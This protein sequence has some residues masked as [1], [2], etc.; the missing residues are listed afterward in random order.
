M[1]TKK[2]LIL[3]SSKGIGKSI[4]LKFEENNIQCECPTSHELDTASLKK[5]DKF[6]SKKREYD[7]VILNTGGPPAKDFYEIKLNEWEK[8]HHQLFLGFVKIFQKLKVNRNGYI[9]LISSHTV[10]SPEKKL[11]LSNTYR[12]ALISLLKT[13][14]SYFSKKNISTLSFAL[15]PIKTQRLKKLVKNLRKFENKLP[16][17][18]AGEPEEIS[19]LI[20]SIV[21]K[22]IKYI[23]GTTINIDGGLSSYIFS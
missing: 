2:A 4:R 9:F 8:Y 12:V 23:N 17:R 19:N 6:F 20:F 5:I 15:G 11:V 16:L 10:K 1:I 14:S 3:G 7:I 22:N 21:D 13:L 18:R